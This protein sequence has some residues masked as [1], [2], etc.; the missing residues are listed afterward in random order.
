MVR[1]HS[2]VEIRTESRDIRISFINIGITTE[3]YQEVE[4]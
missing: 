3:N 2:A 1:D 4:K